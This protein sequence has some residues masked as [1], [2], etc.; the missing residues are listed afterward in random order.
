MPQQ[1]ENCGAATSDHR[2]NVR[3]PGYITPGIYGLSAQQP[4]TG[5][6]CRALDGILRIAPYNLA[7]ASY[8]TKSALRKMEYR[9]LAAPKENIH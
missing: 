1:G 2:S 7:F 9:V 5:A 3:L 8:G 6:Q 4:H